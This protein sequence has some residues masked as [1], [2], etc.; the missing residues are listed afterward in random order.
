MDAAW[1]KLVTFTSYK[2]ENAGRK[3]I[4]VNPYNTSQMCSRCGTIVKKT[5]Q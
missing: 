4:L 2:A 3:V 1:N 5:Y